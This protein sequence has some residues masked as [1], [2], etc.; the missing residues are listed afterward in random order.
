MNGEKSLPSPHLRERVCFSDLISIFVRYS[1]L[2]LRGRLIP[3]N[4]S[5]TAALPHTHKW[6]WMLGMSCKPTNNK[7]LHDLFTWNPHE[8]LSWQMTERIKW[9]FYDTYS[10]QTRSPWKI[11]DNFIIIFNSGAQVDFLHWLF[12]K[13]ENFRTS[14]GSNLGP[15]ACQ[16]DAL[17]TRPPVPC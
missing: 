17:T 15:P 16:A 14:E 13:T 2:H 6:S 4:V 7:G 3:C 11:A 8:G 9:C 1:F 12:H 10:S 5:M